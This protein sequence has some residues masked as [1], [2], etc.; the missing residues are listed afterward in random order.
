[1]ALSLNFATLLTPEHIAQL[2]RG[3]QFTLVL[4]VSSWLIAI[5]VGA[6][7]A[8]LRE[9]RGRW[10]GWAVAGFVSYQ[11]NIPA[12]AHL[13]MWYFGVPA[14][15]PLAAQSWINAHNGEVIL[16]SIAMGLGVGAYFCEDIRSGFRSI[17][18]GQ[19]EASRAIGLSYLQSMRYVI[20][21]QSLRVA[22][23]PLVNHTVM[24]FK[25]TSLAMAIGVAE[26]TYVVREIENQTFRTFESY[27]IAT[28]AYLVISLSLMGL[29]ALIAR[30]YRI[31]GR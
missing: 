26:L 9:G 21:P 31:P 27:L 29:G 2:L 1:V 5:T 19:H 4:T 22:L 16:A 13:L 12:L 8:I 18:Q 10:V 14:L 23:P 25:G 17:P 11:R 20:L 15:L 30:H 6:L 28:V 24:L 7:L 3:L